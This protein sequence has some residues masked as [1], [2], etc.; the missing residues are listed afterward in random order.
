MMVMSMMTTMT[1]V[2]MTKM[3]MAAM[4]SGE[5]GTRKQLFRLA[6]PRQS[7]L[8]SIIIT[9]TMMMITMMITMTIIA[10]T[11]MITFADEDHDGKGCLRC[12]RKSSNCQK[13]FLGE[14]RNVAG[15]RLN[16]ATL[17]KSPQVN[18]SQVEFER[19]ATLKQ[20]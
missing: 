16:L 20:R 10:I 4:C 12:L 15:F 9:I 11:M 3:T 17:G 14:E 1:M 19:L 5:R 6:R 2:M 18:L 13:K 8:I 7:N